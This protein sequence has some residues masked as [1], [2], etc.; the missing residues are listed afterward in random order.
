MKLHRQ[1]QSRA[2]CQ[3]RVTPTDSTGCFHAGSCP[4]PPRYNSAFYREERD[5]AIQTFWTTPMHA[6]ERKFRRWNCIICAKPQC[7]YS[8]GLPRENESRYWWRIIQLHHPP[9]LT[10]KESPWLPH[11]ESMCVSVTQAPH[12]SSMSGPVVHGVKGT[13]E[14]TSQWLVLDK[15]STI[16]RTRPETDARKESNSDTEP[17]SLATPSILTTHYRKVCPSHMSSPTASSS[18]LLHFSSAPF[19]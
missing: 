3:S 17:V 8:C 4:R 14:R 10:H 15:E 19:S 18:T 16:G 9:S 2:S 5:R 7:D 12:W 1:T 13:R 11:K 6:K